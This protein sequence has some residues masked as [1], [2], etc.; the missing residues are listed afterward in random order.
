MWYT[1][2]V[3]AHFKCTL[4]AFLIKP[5]LRMIIY[6]NLV[7]ASE[8]LVRYEAN[9]RRT[10]SA[11][12]LRR[13][14]WIMLFLRPV[15]GMMK[16]GGTQACPGIAPHE[17]LWDRPGWSTEGWNRCISS[18]NC[19]G[20]GFDIVS[21]DGMV[22]VGVRKKHQ[23]PFTRFQTVRTRK[24]CGAQSNYWLYVLQRPM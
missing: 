11:F 6:T 15:G 22:N 2:Q 23:S 21:G 13:S 8:Q 3:I 1:D 16:F 7:S 14:L 9:D 10:Q 18:G 17:Q 4:C 24:R 19:I 20:G 12:F 5:I